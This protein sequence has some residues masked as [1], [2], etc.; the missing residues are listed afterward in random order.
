[1]NK[2]KKVTINTKHSDLETYGVILNV[3]YLIEK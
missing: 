1:M 2:A 3:E